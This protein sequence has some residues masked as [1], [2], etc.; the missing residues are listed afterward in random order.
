MKV[1]Y[2]D[3]YN[4]W[5]PQLQYRVEENGVWKLVLARYDLDAQVQ[6]PEENDLSS[7]GPGYR[8]VVSGDSDFA[9][10]MELKFALDILRTRRWEE[11]Q[12]VKIECYTEYGGKRGEPFLN[13]SR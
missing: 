3:L 6:D 11:G 1:G 10:D 8:G 7:Q 2:T 9:K 13:K 12:G 4:N 5:Y